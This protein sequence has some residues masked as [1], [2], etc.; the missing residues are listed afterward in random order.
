MML[1]IKEFKVN[2]SIKT[3]NMS[4][5]VQGILVFSSWWLLSIYPPHAKRM[6]ERGDT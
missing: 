6:V 2:I 4:V 5:V 1:R 3:H